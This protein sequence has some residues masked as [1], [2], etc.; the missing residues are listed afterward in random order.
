MLEEEKI[1]IICGVQSVED[2]IMGEYDK[3]EKERMEIV[4]KEI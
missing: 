3:G 1:K 2:V 4:E